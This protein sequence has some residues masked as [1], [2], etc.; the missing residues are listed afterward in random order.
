[1]DHQYYI[2]Q[3]VESDID[4]LVK[5]F[6]TWHKTRAQ[7]ERYHHLHQLGNRVVLVAVIGDDIVGYV[8]LIWRTE[9]EHFRLAEIPEIVD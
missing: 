1:M 2:R 5:T 6:T 8:N 7:F 4:G 3:I 9:Y